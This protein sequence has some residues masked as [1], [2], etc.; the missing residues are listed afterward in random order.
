MKYSLIKLVIAGYITWL[1][2]EVLLRSVLINVLH[3]MFGSILSLSSL[4]GLYDMLVIL[5]LFLC[6]MGGFLMIVMCGNRGRSD[7][8]QDA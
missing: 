2:F 3:A 7:E 5:A 4:T 1:L 8:R 6:V